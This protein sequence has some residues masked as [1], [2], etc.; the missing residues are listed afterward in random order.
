MHSVDH[1]CPNKLEKIQNDLVSTPDKIRLRA[2]ESDKANEMFSA[3]DL[4][5]YYGMLEPF[6][7]LLEREGLY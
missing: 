2:S 7:P 5:F 1:V 3:T 6:K 4:D